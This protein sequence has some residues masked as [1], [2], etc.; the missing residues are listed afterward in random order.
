[1]LKIELQDAFKYAYYIGTDA[2]DKNFVIV[3]TS[4]TWCLWEWIGRNI[5][6]FRLSEKKYF[7]DNLCLSGTA[8]CHDICKHSAL[9]LPSE[10]GKHEF[11]FICVFAKDKEKNVNDGLLQEFWD[12]RENKYRF[13]CLRLWFYIFETAFLLLI[14]LICFV[15]PIDNESFREVYAFQFQLFQLIL[16]LRQFRW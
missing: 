6:C 5:Q 13:F 1:M 7:S 9:F 4:K 3:G 14:V 2:L 15:Q 8:F 10:V 16:V 12:L 11:R